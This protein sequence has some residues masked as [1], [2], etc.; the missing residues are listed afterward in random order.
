M[1]E[2]INVYS[3]QSKGPAIVQEVL[4]LAKIKGFKVKE[5]PIVFVNRVKGE[6]KL[7]LK[8]IISGYFAVLKFRILYILGEVK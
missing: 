5:V 6:S 2:K 3:L 8:Q 7:G 1:L 4:F